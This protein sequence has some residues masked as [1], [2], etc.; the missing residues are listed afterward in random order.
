MVFYTHRWDPLVENMVIQPLP[1]RNNVVTL[2]ILK[3]FYHFFL[4]LEIYMLEIYMNE[5]V[6]KN[7]LSFQSFKPIYVKVF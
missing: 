2:Y 5:K 1:V 4:I 6:D 3:V 7:L